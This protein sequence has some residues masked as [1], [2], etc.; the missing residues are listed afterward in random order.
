[1]GGGSEREGCL[2]W[3]CSEAALAWAGAEW[4]LYVRF[5]HQDGARV[6]FDGRKDPPASVNERLVKD[7]E[8]AL[9]TEFTSEDVLGNR[10]GRFGHG[11]VIAFPGA[12]FQAGPDQIL[13][14]L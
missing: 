2:T 6:T 8:A 4:Q 9:E 1:M 10:A 5:V 7:F 3:C 14:H 11:S 12:V 13:C